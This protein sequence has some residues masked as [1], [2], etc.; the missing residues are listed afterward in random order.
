MSSDLNF[1]PLFVVVLCNCSLLVV[2]STTMV[3]PTGRP[4]RRS[5]G[6]DGSLKIDHVIYVRFTHCET[7]SAW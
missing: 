6:E 5:T 3:D 2:F 1:F 7:V 4:F